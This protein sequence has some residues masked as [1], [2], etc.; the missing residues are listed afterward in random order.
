MFWPWEAQSSIRVARESWGLPSS[1][2]RAKETSSRRVSRTSYSSPGKAGTTGLHCRLP[3]GVRPRLEGK[4]R[5]P[6]PSR[7]ATRISWSP[8]SGLMESILLFSLE[9]GL[10]I[11]L[12]A[13]QEIKALSSRGRGPLRGFLELR[14]PWGFSPEARRGSQG[15]SRAA[16]GKSKVM[17]F[18][19]VVYRCQRRLSTE[20]LM[21]SNCGVGEDS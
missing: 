21:L 17:L 10:G 2:C 13:M 5:T 15:A 12:Q 19:V 1:H 11:P 14:R 20:E 16:P 6:L 4:R 9:R 18:P 8:L 7:V 3:R